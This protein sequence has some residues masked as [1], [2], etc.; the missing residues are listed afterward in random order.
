M[1]SFFPR[2]VLDE[3]LNLIESVSEEFPSYSYKIFY[4]SK[5]IPY[6]SSKISNT[7]YKT[8]YMLDK[9][10]SY[11]VADIQWITSCQK[12]RMTTRVTTLW[13]VNV[14]SLTTS[15]SAMRFLFEIVFILKAIKFHSKV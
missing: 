11:D 5:K 13:R 1:L 7:V 9:G 4:M 10:F 3:I 12:N 15:V 6:M 8:S 2:G 14:T